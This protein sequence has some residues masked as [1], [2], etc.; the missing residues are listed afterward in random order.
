V[1]PRCDALPVVA[2][3]GDVR[4]R[5]ELD[6][7]RIADHL[8]HS[9]TT[10]LVLGQLLDVKQFTNGKANL[11][12]LLRFEGRALVLRRPPHGQ[13]AAG[14]HDMAR[15]ARVL[16]AL[17][18]VYDLAPRSVL[19]CDDLAVCGTGFIVLEY[20]EGV[21]LSRRPTA[22]A[23][24]GASVRALA[25]AFVAGVADLH[26]LDAQRP[27]LREL[28]RPDGFVDRQLRGW[29]RR[30]EQ[31]ATDEFDARVRR[32]H[33]ALVARRPAPVAPAVVHMD[34]HLDNVLADPEHLDRPVALLDWDMAT[35]GDPRVDL[36]ILLAY[37]P[38][39]SDP[40]PSPRV[41]HPSIGLMPLPG[42]AEVVELYRSAGGPD[43]TG[44][45]WF[46]AFALWRNVI[47]IRQLVDR[48]E[49]G[50]SSDA[51]ILRVAA[52]LEGLLAAAAELVEA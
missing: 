47:A 16:D 14:A 10:G 15:E 17:A 25:E 27:G 19:R 28:G 5:D 45:E 50:A 32:T 3:A 2:D 20:R 1:T 44:L 11:T 51:D 40:A 12:Y 26:R 38:D 6:W 4:Q 42:R 41:V 18:P 34:L 49:S 43:V 30:W 21:T 8:R 37:W 48:W 46:E 23:D 9:L 31:V 29:R 7:T 24:H 33:A 13:I 52:G 35:L 39:P 22:A 36:G